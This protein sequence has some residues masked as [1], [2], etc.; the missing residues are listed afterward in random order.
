MARA[1]DFDLAKE[2]GKPSFTPAQRDAPALVELV[3]ADHD[4]A[5]AAV[6]GLGEAGRHALEARLADDSGARD[7][8]RAELD[9]A[10]RA[11]IVGA[12][13]LLAR[14]GDA[15]A[16]TVV[17]ARLADPGVRVR[18]AAISA[19]G[20]LAPLAASDPGALE[21]ARAALLAHWDALGGAAPADE[22]RTLVEALGKLGG[23]DVQARLAALAPGDDAELARRR[24][25]AR[26]MADRDAGRAAPSAIITSV[27]GLARW[28]LR[29][30]CKAGLG[31]LLAE[32]V[33]ALGLPVAARDDA[34]IETRCDH[35]DELYRAR[36]WSYAG[37]RVPLARGGARSEARDEAA[38]IVAALTS[39]EVRGL[40]RAMTAGGIR[41][42]LGVPSGHRRALVWR[43]ARDVTAAAPELVNDPSQTTWDVLV[44][45]AD[46]RAGTVLE[47]VPRQAED[48]RFA[49]RTAEVPAASHP[50]V[51][52]ALAFVAGARDGD[53]V[54]DPFCGSG[55][56]LVERA[57]L[58]PCTLLGTDIDD[59]ALAAA[60]ENLAAARVTATLAIADA[61]THAPGPQ[62]LVITNPPLGSRVQVDAAALLCAALPGF[63]RALA[64]NGR[65]VWITPASRKTTPVAEQLGLRRTRDLAIDL[66]GV[67]GRLE[68]WERRSP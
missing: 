55:A 40:L 58:G 49:W 28:P 56:E 39:A 50:T 25:R 2:L 46:A 60:R 65:L 26:L 7:A 22:K 12:L 32:E 42:R 27:G 67:R 8:N 15:A 6:A 45:D 47:L 53:R 4:K 11:R 62:D 59:A 51:A 29:L 66:G 37:V 16:R 61:R 52:A 20:K 1:P 23:P 54:W 13:G 9:E 34:W 43:V 48:P 18:R 30:H 31:P 33:A 44:D 68:R 38:A 35:Y 24:D 17:L 36:L 19:L 64:P 57:R 5:A 14:A 10:G 3:I 63:A 41:W 21:A